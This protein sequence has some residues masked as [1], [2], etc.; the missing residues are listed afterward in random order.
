MSTSWF[1]II[2]DRIERAGRRTVDQIEEPKINHF[3]DPAAKEV[4]M[5][6]Q[7]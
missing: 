1:Q 4:W 7:D 6:R 2:V 5:I 3:N